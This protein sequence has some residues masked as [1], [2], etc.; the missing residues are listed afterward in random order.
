METERLI[1]KKAAFEDWKDMYQN[2]WS[3]EES[4]RYML[5]RVT[6]DEESA[7]ERM[8]RTMEYQKEHMAYTV[9]EKAGGQAIGFAGMEEIAP[10]VYEDT[11]I[12]VGPA[13][14]GKG[15][16][17]EIL[18]ALVEYA[19][20]ELQAKKFVCSCRSGNEASRKMQLSCGF[21]YTHSEDRVDKWRGQEYVLEFYELDALEKLCP[22]R[23]E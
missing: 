22:G 7:Q 10:Q 23:K 19:F 6:Q 15:Y 2:I 17:R 21:V 12:A 5:W 11:G 13:F 18:C 1:I 8:R 16:G 20:L 3:K 9:Y 14:V 4:A